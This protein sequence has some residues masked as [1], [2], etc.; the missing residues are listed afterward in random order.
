M[1]AHIAR[2]RKLLSFQLL[3]LCFFCES[4]QKTITFRFIFISP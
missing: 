1:Q 4:D 3:S 2:W